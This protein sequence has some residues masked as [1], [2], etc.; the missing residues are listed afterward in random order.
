MHK[1][2]IKISYL[3]LT[4]LLFSTNISHAG[5][6]KK[7]TQNII[8][9]AEK[10]ENKWTETVDKIDGLKENAKNIKQNIKENWENFKNC[11]K[12]HEQCISEK[13]ITEDLLNQCN[14]DLESLE[15][16]KI[17]YPNYPEETAYQLSKVNNI[18]C[19]N[20]H[21]GT[22]NYYLLTD[23][24]NLDD[25]INIGVIKLDQSENI[26][27]ALPYQHG[28]LLIIKT[29]ILNKPGFYISTINTNLNKNTI[30][31]TLSEYYSKNHIL[32]KDILKTYD[33]SEIMNINSDG[34]YFNMIYYNTIDT[35]GNSIAK[36]LVLNYFSDSDSD[37]IITEI[38]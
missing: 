12:N 28:V 22:E 24:T 23:I 7:I 8:E 18:K 31:Y 10:I 21:L 4:I 6:I 26:Y 35:Y 15:I 13:K 11:P 37:N 1:I 33:N 29:H 38:N 5:L 27:K 17:N 16:L 19:S 14:K 32:E 30:K 3:I 2:Y 9:T 34:G 25:K 36:Q 20:K